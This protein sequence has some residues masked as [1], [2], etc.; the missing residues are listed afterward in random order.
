MKRGTYK[1]C[2]RKRNNLIKQLK[3]LCRVDYKIDNKTLIL[4]LDISKTE[5]YRNYK[6]IADE[7]RKLNR[8]ESL[9]N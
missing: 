4:K 9:F 7:C 1:K 3:E 8:S 2:T 6:A 5:F